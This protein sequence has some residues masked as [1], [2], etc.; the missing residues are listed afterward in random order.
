MSVFKLND[1][2]LAWSALFLSSTSLFCC[3]L[4]SLLVTLGM[5]SVV[6]FLTAH[7]QILVSIS[8]YKFMLLLISGVLIILA[9]LQINQIQQKCAWQKGGE[10]VCASFVTV[11]KTILF[12]AK[13]L[14]SIGF[15][16]GYLLLP[17]LLLFGY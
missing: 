17:I 11:Q 3:A 6:I 12:V 7:F 10:N 8:E 15:M 16:T 4:P 13:I 5:S 2:L 9:Q 1:K 14:W